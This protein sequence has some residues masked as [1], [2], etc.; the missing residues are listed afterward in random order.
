MY[1]LKLDWD[2]ERIEA[3]RHALREWIEAQRREDSTL[4]V[5]R[6]DEVLAAVADIDLYRG[7]VAEVKE[8][9]TTATTGYC[10]YC[11]EYIELVDGRWRDNTH[12]SLR[13]YCPRDTHPDHRHEKYE[14]EGATQ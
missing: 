6:A 10:K 8:S 13:S 2:E 7:A 14:P 3:V 9:L 5:G 1:T 12:T 4:P 11:G